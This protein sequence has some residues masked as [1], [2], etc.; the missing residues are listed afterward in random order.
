MQYSVPQFTDVEDKIIAGLTLKQFG[1]LGAG[2]AL[3]FLLYTGTKS[4]IVGIFAFLIFGMPA[5]ILTFAKING[6]PL[7]STFYPYLQYMVSPRVLI[8]SKQGL[9][10]SHQILMDQETKQADTSLPKVEQESA[11]VRLHKLNY[12]LSQQVEAETA[13]AD[14]P[15]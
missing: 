2:A 6:R 5:L 10:S 13:L 9:D 12:T 7:Y 14:K 1:I 8:F 11:T 3:T 15:L 4:I